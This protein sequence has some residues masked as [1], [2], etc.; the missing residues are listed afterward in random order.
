[1]VEL[2]Q[3]AYQT[4][5]GWLA[6]ARRR[7]QPPPRWAF[8]LLGPPPPTR[9]AE[10]AAR[11]RAAYRAVFIS[12]LHLGTPSCH[13][14][15]VGHF[16]SSIDAHTLYLVGDIVDLWLMCRRV[17]WP[18]AQVEVVRALLHLAARGTRIVYLPGNHDSWLRRLAGT[19]WGAFEV[20][21]RAVHESLAG[22]RYLVLHGDQVDRAVSFSPWLAH[23]GARLYSSLVV[24]GRRLRRRSDGPSL[25]RLGKHLA[26]RLCPGTR[27]FADNLRA[28]AAEH[29]LDGVICGH[30]HEARL[31]E[32]GQR[33]I[34]YHNCGDWVEACT[35]LVERLDG[36]WGLLTWRDGEE[37]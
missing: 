33:G 7:R 35:A 34:A 36:S 20:A 27:G 2:P 17:H 16:L 22:R 6:E 9:L 13:A 23:L 25:A 21:D 1:M 32:A 24:L 37:S 31:D 14:G 30:S 11:A 5:Q 19:R 10:P 28:A 3:P 12:D 8:E 15:R 29:G 26:K 18:A 4:S